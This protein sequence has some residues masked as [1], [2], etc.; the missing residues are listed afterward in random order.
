M[1]GSLYASSKRTGRRMLKKEVR[2]PKK[3]IERVRMKK[4]KTRFFHYEKPY[5]FI[6]KVPAQHIEAVRI[7]LQRL[8]DG[9]PNVGFFGTSGAYRMKDGSL[10][11]DLRLHALRTNHKKAHSLIKQVSQ[12]CKTPWLERVLL[13]TEPEYNQFIFS[14]DGELWAVVW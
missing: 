6:G 8:S 14:T 1:A 4:R 10:G 11:F 7:F 9:I 13:K 12:T 3:K 2:M 5:N